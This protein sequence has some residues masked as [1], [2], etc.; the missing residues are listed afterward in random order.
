IEEIP[1]NPCVD[2][3]PEGSI[4]I[5]GDPIMGLPV[6]EGN[7]IAC[8]RCVAI[9]PGLAINLVKPDYDGEKGTSLLTFPFELD[10]GGLAPGSAVATVDME[11]NRVGE[12]TIKRFR[13]SP[14]QDQRR[15]VTVEVPKDE[16]F[17]VAGFTVLEPEEGRPEPFE[18][19]P[20]PDDTIVCRCER[21]T[22][23]EVRAEIRA[24]VRD[25]NILKATI[26]TGMGACGGKTCTDLILR[27]YREEGIDPCDVTLP[28]SRPFT[29]EV[30]LKA[31]AGIDGGKK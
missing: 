16:A 13:A 17:L 22:A 7:C 2:S 19:E 20:I 6:F 23:G 18:G 9:C 21:I 10:G 3:C 31:F 5:K 25:M 30:H 1:C 14:I 11:G 28:T 15:L 29:A 26:R 8:G 24:G 4:V 12:G 27:L